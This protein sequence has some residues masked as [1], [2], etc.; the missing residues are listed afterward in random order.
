LEEILKAILGGLSQESTEKGQEEQTSGDMIMDLLGDILGGNAAQEGQADASP[1]ANP[2]GEIIGSLIGGGGAGGNSPIMDFVGAILGGGDGDSSG[3][4]SKNP[5]AQYLA[6]KL[7][8]SPMIAEAIVAF[9]MAKVVATLA[10]NMMGM[11]G[12]QAE[13]EGA[14]DEGLNL[15]HLLESAE[16]EQVLDMKLRATGMPQE[17]ADSANIDQDTATRGLQELVKLVANQKQTAT[18]VTTP[19]SN[20]KGLLDS[21]ETD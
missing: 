18:P 15:D 2:L 3:K 19:Q 21:W 4:E 16:D 20:L 7:G 8:I 5:I 12:A 1:A 17:L 11:M 13:L 10:P 14:K 6:E 9:F